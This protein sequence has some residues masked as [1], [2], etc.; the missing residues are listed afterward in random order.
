MLICHEHHV[1][2]LSRRIPVSLNEPKKKR[3]ITGLPAMGTTFPHPT[4]KPADFLSEPGQGK[5]P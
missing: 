3:D 5:H 2:L 1:R 4:P